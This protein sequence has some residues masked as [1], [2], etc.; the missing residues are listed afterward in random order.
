[1]QQFLHHG[2][3][4][5]RNV[6][7]Q[8]P[9]GAGG[10]YAP[11]AH[12]IFDLHGDAGKRGTLSCRNPVVGFLGLLQRQFPGDGNEGLYPVFDLVNSVQAGLSKLHRVDFPAGEPLLGFMNG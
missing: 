6:F 3:V 1:M 2:G 12:D 7:F 11:G 9:G 8:H 5:D 4:V 10:T